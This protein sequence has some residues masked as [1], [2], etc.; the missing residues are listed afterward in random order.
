MVKKNYI[1]LSKPFLTVNGDLIRSPVAAYEE[2]GNPHGR[3]VLLCHG[4][5][6]SQH[7]AD[8]TEEDPLPGWWDELV[9]P[10]NVFD[11]D[12]FRIISINALGS[13]AGSSSAITLNPDTGKPYG[14]H[15]PYVTMADHAEFLRQVLGELG[16]DHLFWAAGLSMG[17]LAVMQLALM[18]PDFVGAITPVA[19]AACMPPGG[20]AIHNCFIEMIRRADGWERGEQT[21]DVRLALAA[22]SMVSKVYYTHYLLY[23][24]MGRFLKS[25][26]EIEEKIA[27]YIGAG[28]DEY[29]LSHNENCVISCLRACNSYD[30]A[31]G[32][33]S[34]D[35]AFARYTMPA[36]VI[37]TDTDPEFSP[38]YGRQIVEGINRHYPGNAD[39]YMIHSIYGHMAC[40]LETGQLKEAMM[41]FKEKILMR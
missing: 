21:P 37:S 4:G 23:E 14:R 17:S 22:M 13:I 40:K 26:A 10:G 6:S 5:L 8:V 27:A 29:Y 18:Y 28:A 33:E 3:P 30:I 35:A 15:F 11:T 31:K 9:G 41:P 25:Q 34:L 38:Q 36:L 39:F 2:Y 1:T 7:A 24:G 19:T 20:V 12:I 32:Y 16:V